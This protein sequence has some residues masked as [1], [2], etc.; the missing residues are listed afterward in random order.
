MSFKKTITFSILLHLCFFAA[1]VLLPAGLLGNGNKIPRE[2]VFFVNLA[3]DTGESGNGQSTVYHVRKE[4][5]FPIGVKIKKSKLEKSQQVETEKK[6]VLDIKN[7]TVSVETDV[8]SE[9]PPTSPFFKGGL[10]NFPPLLKGGEGGFERGSSGKD[11]IADISSKEITTV[12]ISY[13]SFS[14]KSRGASE[15][16]KGDGVLSAEIFELIRN[17]IE[18]AKTYPVI[19][20]K[21]G[22]EGTVYIS[23]K[24]NAQ[25]K[26]QELKILKSSGSNILDTATRDIVKRAAPF[27]Y[28]DSPVEVPVVFRLD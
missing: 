7:K 17:S 20:R 19:A 9:N 13:E 16:N 10:N 8:A 1:V 26:P 11:N 18:R 15:G 14:S 23:F 21:R 5:F 2:K 6:P 4:N 22:I 27:P 28:V 25:G 24:I 3:K 12:N